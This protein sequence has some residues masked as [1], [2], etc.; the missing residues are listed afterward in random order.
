[1]PT[2]DQTKATVTVRVG[3]KQKEARILPQMG[4]RVSFL[5]DTPQDHDTA[6]P[7]DPAVVVPPE[8][9][10]SEGTSAAVW[11]IDGDKTVRHTV[12]LGARN[13]GGQTI[14]SGVDPGAIVVVGDS[15]KLADGTR[16]RVV[17]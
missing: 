11:V 9:V 17:Q 2:A 7:V 5:E 12:R 10:Q 6:R 13:S 1:I 16:V 8:A 3:F 15:T 4:A 14:L